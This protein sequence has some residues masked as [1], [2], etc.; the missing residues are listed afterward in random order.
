MKSWLTFCSP[1]IDKGQ[2]MTCRKDGLGRNR[3][4]GDSLK[5]SATSFGAGTVSSTCRNRPRVAGG[6][7]G[8][9]SGS[10]EVVDGDAFRHSRELSSCDSDGGITTK[11]PVFD[12]LD[13][14]HERVNRFQ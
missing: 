9:V 14:Y 13:H 5:V 2:G 6:T 10:G 8:R 7:E 3:D 1:P 4:L 11:I 12:R